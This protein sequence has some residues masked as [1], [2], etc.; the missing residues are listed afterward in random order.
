MSNGTVASTDFTQPSPPV[1]R[2]RGRRVIDALK[3]HLIPSR[4]AE[5]R[6]LAMVAF[7]VENGSHSPAGRTSETKG[8]N[9]SSTNGNGHR[10]LTGAELLERYPS[11]WITPDPFLRD[12]AR[13]EAL[14]HARPKWVRD[15]YKAQRRRPSDWYI[16]PIG[17]DVID[18]IHATP[19]EFAELVQLARM[20]TYDHEQRAITERRFQQ[21]ADGT[22]PDVA[23]LQHAE[24]ELVQRVTTK[25]QDLI[26]ERF[27]SATDPPS[28]S[29]TAPQADSD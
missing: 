15:R 18:A 11:L 14:Q 19:D 9:G 12:R 7:S 20:T 8:S 26:N 24:E 21:L 3:N 25:H 13:L 10:E 17:P 2:G 4:R 27:E 5:V 29:T 22:L 1:L 16:G 6:R 23:T 28:T